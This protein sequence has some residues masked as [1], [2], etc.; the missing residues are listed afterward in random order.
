MTRQLE[1]FC[2][3]D[4]GTVLRVFG[5]LTLSNVE[6]FASEISK[7]FVLNAN[8]LYLDLNRCSVKVIL[9]RIEEEY[10]QAVAEEIPQRA[11][12]LALY[13][14]LARANRKAKEFYIISNDTKY[15]L[16]F[17]VLKFF[18]YN[19]KPEDRLMSTLCS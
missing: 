2:V 18:D 4:E 3:D 1:A 13:R 16:K 14:S 7:E 9:D 19:L 11:S 8:R 15:P 5:V 6:A 17:S 10:E 12:L